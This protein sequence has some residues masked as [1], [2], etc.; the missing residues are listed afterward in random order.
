MLRTRTASERPAR[1]IDQGDWNMAYLFPREVAEARERIGLVILPVAPI[2]WHGPHVAMGCDSLLAH[3][4]AREVARKLRCPYYPPLVVGTERER[5]DW[6][7]RSI[8]FRGDEFVEG[9][10]F[11]KN[12]VASGY[13]REEV[14]AAVVR[15]TLNRLEGNLD[16]E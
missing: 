10:D 4:F 16:L 2:E 6:M 1:L 12:T 15:D 14:F 11:P 13:Y 3:A 8:G 9:M 5:S 7:L